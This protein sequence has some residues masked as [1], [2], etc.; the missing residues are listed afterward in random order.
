MDTGIEKPNN[1]HIGNWQYAV[2]TEN[3]EAD[4]TLLN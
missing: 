3:L 2:L 4:C 1:L